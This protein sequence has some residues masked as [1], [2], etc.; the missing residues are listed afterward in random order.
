[1][2]Q[3][4]LPAADPDL[5]VEDERTKLYTKYLSSNYPSFSWVA[6]RVRPTDQYKIRDRRRRLSCLLPA[7][8]LVCV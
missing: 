5:D 8:L 3:T 1:M 4:D 7:C 6:Y 2:C